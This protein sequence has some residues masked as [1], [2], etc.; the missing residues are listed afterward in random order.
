[1]E[2]LD[3]LDGEDGAVLSDREIRS[4]ARRQ[5]VGSLVA[6]ALIAIAASAT[7]LR[8]ASHDAADIAPYKFAIHQPSLATLPGQRVATIARHEIE[9][10]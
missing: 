5:L 7:A 2:N 1:M 9:L 6:I 10:P 4:T 3:Y 8:P